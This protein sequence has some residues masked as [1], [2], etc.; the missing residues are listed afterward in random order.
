MS[1]PSKETLLDQMRARLRKHG[2]RCLQMTLQRG[3]W[4]RLLRVCNVFTGGAA[5]DLGMDTSSSDLGGQSDSDDSWSRPLKKPKQ[6]SR[7]QRTV[8]AATACRPP[9]PTKAAPK[10]MPQY[11]AKYREA[12]GA[13]LA[14]KAGEKPSACPMTGQVVGCKRRWD[15]G[16]PD[17]YPHLSHRWCCWYRGAGNG[18]LCDICGELS[19]CSQGPGSSHDC[20]TRQHVA[21]TRTTLIGGWGAAAAEFR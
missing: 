13:L 1:G 11:L 18:G 3:A 2:C 17:G 16:F 19:T 20:R 9:A 5:G 4:Y 6:S 10:P 12:A 21:K 8:Q 15:S 7:A 14:R